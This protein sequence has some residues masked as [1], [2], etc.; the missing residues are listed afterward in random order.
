DAAEVEA[1]A[2]PGGANAGGEQFG[3]EQRQPAEID[4]AEEAEGGDPEEEPAIGRVEEPEGVL[5]DEQ[6]GEA[7]QRVGQPAS[8]VCGDPAAEQAA[9][10]AGQGSRL[11][12]LRLQFRPGGLIRPGD[13]PVGAAPGAD[14]GD[15]GQG[16]ADQGDA[17]ERRAKNLVQRG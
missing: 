16:D 1:D 2:G 5:G 3:Q 7:D 8:N 12:D 10:D 11:L 9:D 17:Q 4:A 14:H 13:H 15:G 6:G